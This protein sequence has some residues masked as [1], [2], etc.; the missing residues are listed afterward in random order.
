MVQT[1][2]APR[3]RLLRKIADRGQPFVAMIRKFTDRRGY[4][5][6]ADGHTLVREHQLVA[7]VENDPHDVFSEDTDVHHLTPTFQSAGIKLDIPGSVCVIERSEHRRLHA[8]GDH[9]SVPIESV[10]DS[11]NKEPKELDGL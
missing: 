8:N 4:T 3:V 2:R 11:S 10:L 7:L 1:D 6:Y 5:I 9:T